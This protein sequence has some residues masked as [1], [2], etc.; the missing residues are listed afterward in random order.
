MLRWLLRLLLLAVVLGGFSLFLANQWLEKNFTASGPSLEEQV[1]LLPRGSGLSTISVLLER[2]GLIEDPLVFKLGVRKAGAQADL[3]AG[4][5]AIPAG[6]SPREIMEILR[7]GKVIVRRVTVPEGLTSREVLALVGAAEQLT[8]EL[9]PPPPE[10]SLLPE[11]YHYE[12]GDSAGALL[13]R[14]EEAMRETLSQLW[15]GRAEGLPLKTPEEAV[16]LAS[17]VEKETGVGA[18]RPLVASVFYNRLRLGMPLQSDPTVIFALTKGEKELGRALTRQDW[19][20]DDPYNTY[21]NAGLP[22]GPIANPGREALAAVLNPVESEYLYFVA[23][24]TGGHAF[25]KTLAEHN[26]NVA[27]WRKVQKSRTQ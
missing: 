4:E 22:P 3:K 2:E 18:E 21:Q 23:D 27:N 24:G 6:A 20:V 19:K 7:E 26:R 12:R 9:P 10:G 8:G 14:M 5:Y 16:I 11:T 17:I 13:G 25:A 15:D 1:L